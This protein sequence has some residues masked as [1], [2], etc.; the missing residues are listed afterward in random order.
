VG[1]SERMCDLA[2]VVD[3]EENLLEWPTVSGE[4][5]LPGPRGRSEWV[6]RSVV[7]VAVEH[8]TGTDPRGD[9]HEVLQLPG[10][11]WQRSWPRTTNA[12]LNLGHAATQAELT[13]LQNLHVGLPGKSDCLDT[14]ERW[15]NL[16]ETG[17]DLH[18]ALEGIGRFARFDGTCAL[19]PLG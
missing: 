12:Y 14:A 4:Q 19:W 9:Q 10:G 15:N 2:E 8:V 11:E 6:S 16:Q 18:R 17:V 1:L 3:A 5:G 13:A 7:L